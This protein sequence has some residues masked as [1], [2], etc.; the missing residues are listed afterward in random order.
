MTLTLDRTVKSIDSRTKFHLQSHL[1]NNRH[2]DKSSYLKL[3][4]L[5][6][7]KTVAKISKS[8][9]LN[10]CFDLSNEPCSYPDLPKHSYLVACVDLWEDIQVVAVYSLNQMKIIQSNHAARQYTDVQ[11]RV[12]E[13]SKDVESALLTG[14]DLEKGCILST[15]DSIRSKL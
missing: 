14:V 1:I 15:L 10:S 7:L 8:E 5:E 6:Q 2:R 9:K 11:W 3:G 13:L 12:L 4:T